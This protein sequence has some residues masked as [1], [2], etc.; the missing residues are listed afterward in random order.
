MLDKNTVYKRTGSC[1]R[2][3]S[4]RVVCE[5]PLPKTMMPICPSGMAYKFDSYFG[6]GRVTIGRKYIEEAFEYND[7]LADL[8]FN[9]TLCGAC[10]VQCP[11]IGYDPVEITMFL[12]E[13]AHRKG[14]KNK[15][16]QDNVSSSNAAPEI[17]ADEG[18]GVALLIPPCDDGQ[19]EK[20]GSLLSAA[21]VKF[22]SFSKTAGCLL[23]RNGDEEG[24]EKA[25]SDFIA[26]LN[27][28]GIKELIIYDTL[29]Y[30]TI[31]LDYK[32]EE[33]DVKFYLD[34]L[35]ALPLKALAQ[36]KKAAYHDPA[37]L[38]RYTMYSDMPRKILDGVGNLTQIE[39]KRTKK[40]T[41]SSTSYPDCDEKVVAVT[42]SARLAEAADIGASMIITPCIYEYRALVKQAGVD[43]SSIEIKEMAELLNSLL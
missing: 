22:Q 25:K 29:A 14:F 7:S 18:C 23:K 40:N 36:E 11:I 3:K 19:A 9:C 33:V 10:E 39:F 6:M 4:C 31:L 28:A 5:L 2:C 30:K 42:A 32:L 1:A 41:L 34:Y 15:Y 43:N 17:G 20:V 35:E 12:R 13:E 16:L 24:F 21:G 38:G 37:Y 27:A 8:V 26:A